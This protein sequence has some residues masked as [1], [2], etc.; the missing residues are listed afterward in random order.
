MIPI[1]TLITLL[2]TGLFIC[3]G[4]FIPVCGASSYEKITCI[5][6]HC[7]TTSVFDGSNYWHNWYRPSGYEPRYYYPEYTGPYY[8]TPP[9]YDSSYY[10]Q[11]YYNPSYYGPY[12]TIQY[13]GHLCSG[14]YRV[15]CFRI[16]GERSYIEWSLN[17]NCYGGYEPV[18]MS[19]GTDAIVSSRQM[20]CGADFDLYV[21]ENQ[22]PC[23]WCQADRVDVSSGSN[24]YV[25][26]RYPCNGCYY[27][28]VVYCKGGCGDYRLTCNSYNDWSWYPYYTPAMTAYNTHQMSPSMYPSMDPSMPPV[29][30]PSIE[31][32]V[33][34]AMYS[35]RQTAFTT[36]MSE[37]D[38]SSFVWV[39]D[40]SPD[41][42]GQMVASGYDDSGSADT[43]YNPDNDSRT[44]GEEEDDYSYGVSES[45]G[46]FMR[47]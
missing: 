1:K 17:S 30:S 47:S 16:G 35:G 6:G 2:I 27:C 24:A 39:G 36:T 38:T 15:Y 34:E 19:M 32:A 40:E 3:A 14:Q 45:G 18:M 42:D 41:E 13:D 9:Y 28:V 29:M 25:G 43:M 44:D 5:N 37:P 12:R 8:Y 20:Y 11:S 23:T 7:S 33:D 22:Q 10:S 46:F 31:S 4:I 21:Y 26:W